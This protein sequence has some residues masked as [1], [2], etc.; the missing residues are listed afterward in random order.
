MDKN[1]IKVTTEHYEGDP[2]VSQVYGWDVCR[3]N[4]GQDSVAFDTRIE[5]NQI[6][7]VVLTPNQDLIVLR[8]G[9][10]YFILGG[11]DVINQIRDLGMLPQIEI[12]RKPKLC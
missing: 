4:P 8:D 11:H 12:L 10:V 7:T 3:D 1:F 2:I 5:L 6:S 9:K